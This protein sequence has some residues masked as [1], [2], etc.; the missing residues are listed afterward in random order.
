[1]AESGAA[2]AAAALAELRIPL[3]YNPGEEVPESS[4]S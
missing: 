4:Y 3:Q 1:M 2:A